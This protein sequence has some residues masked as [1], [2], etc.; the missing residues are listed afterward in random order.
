ME[1]GEE[2]RRR[3]KRDGRRHLEGAGSSLRPSCSFI[4]E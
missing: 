2:E 4:V 3:A 1:I